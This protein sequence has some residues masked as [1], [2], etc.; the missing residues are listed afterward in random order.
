METIAPYADSMAD[1][2]ADLGEGLIE[3]IGKSINSMLV[4][5]GGN[6][7]GDIVEFLNVAYEPIKKGFRTGDWS[8]FGETVAQYGVAAAVSAVLVIGSVA[9]ATAVAGP[10][11][12]A[13]VAA[14]W[15]AWGLYD[16]ITNGVELLGKISADLANVI[17]K[18][19]ETI[20]DIGS[21]IEKYVGVISRIVANA[22]DVDF[23]AP[24]FAGAD[25]PNAL[26][27][28]YLVDGLDPSLPGSIT[29][30]DK[31]ERFYGKNGASVDARGGNDEVYVR[32]TSRALGGTG[33]DILAGAS[34]KFV[35]ATETTEEQRMVLDGGFGDDWVFALGGTGAVTVGGAG[36]DFLYNS[37]FKGQLW[38]DGLD[39]RGA[40]AASNDRT[41][42][43]IFWWSAGSFIMDAGKNDRLQL[44]GLPLVGGSNALYYG[45][46]LERAVARDWL[47][48]W[49][50]Y[51]MTEAGQLLI[52]AS[53]GKQL[54]P[55]MGADAILEVA[56]V[57]ENWQPGDLGIEFIVKGGGDEISLLK[58]LFKL[59]GA[60]ADAIKRFGKNLAW[61]PTDDPLVLDLNGDGLVSKGLGAVYF[62]QDGDGFAER[63]GWIDGNDGFLVH[64]AD[65]SG[66]ID[67]ISE[68]FGSPGV[69]GYAELR[70]WDDNGDG[71][72]NSEDARF[73]D[74][75]VWRDIDGDAV[76][77]A[78]ELYSLADLNINALSAHGVTR[79]IETANGTIIRADSFFTRVDGTTGQ[80]GELIFETDRVTARYRGDNGIASWAN[81]YEASPAVVGDASTGSGRRVVNANGYGRMTD[82][83]VAVSQDIRVADALAAVQANMA[84]TGGISGVGTI[85]APGDGIAPL[86]STLRRQ[87]QP[88]LAVW[89]NA[90][91]STR[92]LTA[93]LVSADGKTKLDE[94]IYHEDASGGYWALKSGA[95]ILDT[96]SAP[97]AR[98]GLEQVTTGG[99]VAANDNEANG[100]AIDFACF[101]FEEPEEVGGRFRRGVGRIA[102]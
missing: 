18:I 100:E 16:A 65:G 96:Q 11:A 89:T 39:G 69:S 74:L 24:I 33:D 2:V 40:A 5:L 19:G 98:P 31:A 28:K 88:L 90:K 32:D 75:K 6:A 7:I 86:L 29:G 78:G 37:S 67:D 85:A 46:G 44:F 83:A 26:V 38:G 66:T 8:D 15:A 50:T 64:D 55:A 76:T 54:N 70:T 71:I 21:A 23:N 14:G 87:V 49:V 82:L 43:D 45:V 79:N 80:M 22:M 63:S 81:S 9:L 27:R 94:A 41:S 92:E 35:A 77:D 13:F 84:A 56:Q 48:P 3:T 59:L 61:L 91:V 36:S 93:V 34:A 68:M 10:I 95:L 25:G 99:A 58:S 51:G 52:E 20:E 12:A 57:V 1:S 42:D 72:I 102:A 101:S 60:Q 73:A 53:F 17:P 30:S 97:I 4:G 62:D 47:L